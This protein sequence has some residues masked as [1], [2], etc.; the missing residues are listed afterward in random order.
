MKSFLLLAALL[1]APA[2]QVQDSTHSGGTLQASH[3]R[4]ILEGSY[5]T[6]LS[7]YRIVRSGEPLVF[8]AARLPGQLM[9]MRS[10]FGP[11]FALEAQQLVDV[12]RLT[13]PGGPAGVAEIHIRYLV[14]GDF[15]RI[16]IFVPNAST[17]AGEGAH[18]V[19]VLGAA[20]ESDA[21]DAVPPLERQPDGSLAAI[22]SELPSVV[23]LPAATG[24][25]PL[26]WIA[27]ATAALLVLG[28]AGYLAQR[29]LR[30]GR[31]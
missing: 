31:S 21:G 26:A 27:V 22:P 3:V 28:S 17:V 1:H 10:A 18:Y 29:M 7:T 24:S 20:E 14:E 4:I 19:E 25:L 15:S 11:G 30:A 8:D 5:A 16:P 12:R 9:I 2:L 13:A 23:S 6:V